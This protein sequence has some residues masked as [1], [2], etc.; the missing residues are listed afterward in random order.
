MTGLCHRSSAGTTPQTE[1]QYSLSGPETA[2]LN[3]YIKEALVAGFIQ[4]ST[5]PAGAGFFFVGKRDGGLRH[6]IAY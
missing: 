1:G 5:S 4:P 2:D 3:S 6:C